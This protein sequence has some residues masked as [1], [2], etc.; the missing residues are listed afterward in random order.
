MTKDFKNAGASIMLERSQLFD[1]TSRAS[2]TLNA[3][4]NLGKRNIFHPLSK[5][6]KVDPIAESVTPTHSIITKNY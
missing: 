5:S 1:R 4:V 6:I 3:T 2:S